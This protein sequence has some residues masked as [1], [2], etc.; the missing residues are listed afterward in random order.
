MFIA[1]NTFRQKIDLWDFPGGQVVKKLPF[2][3][4]DMGSITSWRIKI[5]HESETALQQEITPATTKDRWSQR[6]KE[7]KKEI[8]NKK[9]NF[10]F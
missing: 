10:V 7:R 9:H 4:G 1:I 8:S 5:L 6:K 2:N 3:E